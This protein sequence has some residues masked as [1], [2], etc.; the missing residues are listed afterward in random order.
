MKGL[1]M[2][3][4]VIIIAI[5]LLVTALVVMTIFGGQIA[6]F[7]GILNPWSAGMLESN[8]CSQACAT[9]CSLNQGSSG[10]DWSTLTVDTQTQDNKPCHV[11]M[12]EVVGNV[13]Q[14]GRCEC[15]GI[16]PSTGKTVNLGG[17]CD[18]SKSQC[19]EGTCKISSGT[20]GTATAVYTCQ[21]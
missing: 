21:K 11:I 4:N 2:T 8:L 12:T 5:V 9:W 14:I 16:V 15:L 3:M 19:I 20:A 17:V 18:P 1:S 7:L 6:Q 13:N 10:T